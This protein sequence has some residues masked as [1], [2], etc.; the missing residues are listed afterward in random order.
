MHSAQ[1]YID[2]LKSSG[3][4]ITKVRRLTIEVLV[5]LKRPLSVSELLFNYKQH[6]LAVNKTTAYREIDFL[7][8]RKIVREIDLLDG[9]KRYELIGDDH[10]HHLV[11]TDCKQVRCVEMKHDLDHVERMIKRRHGFS[12]KSHVL[13]FFGLCKECLKPAK[14]VSRVS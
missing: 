14:M 5:A 12:V 9:M 2:L 6:D 1:H 11:C 8:L 13:E 4:R 10:H 7:L 3:E